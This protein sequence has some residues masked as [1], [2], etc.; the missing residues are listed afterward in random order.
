[1][2]VNFSRYPI[3]DADMWVY[4]YLSDLTIRVF[5]KYQ[6]LVF[7]DVVEQEILEWENKNKKFRNISLYFK[8]CKEDGLI[9]VIN[10]EVDVESEDRDYFEQ[11]LI[12]LD[13]SH[14]LMNNPREKNK[15]E[16][17][18]AMYADHFE[19]PF[20]LTNDK[21]FQEGGIGKVLYPDLK[22]KNFYQIVEEFGKNDDEKIK[23]RSL[24][25]QKQEI[26]QRSFEKQK[27]EDKKELLLNT[28]KEKINSRR[29]T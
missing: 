14:G 19:M 23:I 27:E 3:C 11:V 4:L 6:I 22:I 17:V 10:H 28:L 26:M 24:V 2:S 21:A 29:L 18:S 8:R 1:M 25:H 9:V 16:I 15:G 20:F 5:E 7:A 13:F 12:D